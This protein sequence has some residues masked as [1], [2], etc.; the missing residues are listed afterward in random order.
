[1]YRFEITSSSISNVTKEIIIPDNNLNSVKSALD[2]MFDN[3]NKNYIMYKDL[4][5]DHN[6]GSYYDISKK[7]IVEFKLNLLFDFYFSEIAFSNSSCCYL[8]KGM[9]YTEMVYFNQKPLSSYYD[10]IKIGT[11]VLDDITRDKTKTR[12]NITYKK[13][14]NV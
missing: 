6:S 11:G 3:T 1:M 4:H 8:F 10:L 9:Q 2:I 14:Y 7:I 13:D 12:N 5:Y